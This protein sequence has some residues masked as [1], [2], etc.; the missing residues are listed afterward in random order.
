[1]ESD[2][3]DGHYKGARQV[4]GKC[5]ST[6]CEIITMVTKCFYHFKAFQVYDLTL[7][8]KLAWTLGTFHS[9]SLVSELDTQYVR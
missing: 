4:Y 3:G 5:L 8:V 9:C 2:Y 6:S 1:M 7:M